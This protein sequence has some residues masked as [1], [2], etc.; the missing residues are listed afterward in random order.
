MGAGNFRGAR[1]LRSKAAAKYLGVSD[2]TIRK[3]AHQGEIRYIQL[4]PRSPMLFDVADLDDWIEQNKLC[5][6]EVTV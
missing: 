3:L 2:W 6:E 1:L 5:A 4:T